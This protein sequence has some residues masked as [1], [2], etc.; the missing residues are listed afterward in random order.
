M[1]LDW[2]GVICVFIATVLLTGRHPQV[3]ILGFVVMVLANWFF[4]WYGMIVSSEA[5][6]FSSVVFVVLNAYG[7]YR[8]IVYLNGEE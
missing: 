8:N 1:T 3:R 2:Q 7:I 5:L 6:M 4:F